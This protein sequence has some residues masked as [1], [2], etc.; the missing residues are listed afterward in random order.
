VSC[1]N[2]RLGQNDDPGDRRQAGKAAAGLYSG[3]RRLEYRGHDRLTCRAGR[4][5]VLEASK[6]SQSG[7]QSVDRQEVR[8]AGSSEIARQIVELDA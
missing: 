1:E 3:R 4:I 7:D 5:V 6:A 2:R 8:V